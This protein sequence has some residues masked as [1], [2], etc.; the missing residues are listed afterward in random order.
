MRYL[1]KYERSDRLLCCKL[2]HN[3]DNGEAQDSFV[4]KVY[5]PATYFSWMNFELLSLHAFAWT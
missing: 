1:P 4:P 3:I 5:A 2:Q